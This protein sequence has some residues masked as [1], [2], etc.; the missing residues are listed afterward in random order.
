MQKAVPDSPR[1]SLKYLKEYRLSHKADIQ[2]VFA[3]SKKVTHRYLL[4]LYK[5]NSLQHA[6]LGM[7]ITKARLPK[8]VDRNRLKRVIREGFRHQMAKLPAV[9]IIVMLRGKP[10]DDAKSLRI[11][12]DNLL[13][14]L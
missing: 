4:A 8:A 14:L 9:D 7:I 3:Q 10:D 13:S 2:S 6:R 5:P 1:K 11:E 12:I